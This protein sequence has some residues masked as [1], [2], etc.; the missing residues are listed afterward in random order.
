MRVIFATS[1][2]LNQLKEARRWFIDGT[3]KLVKP[4]FYQ[5]STMH[6]FVKKGDDTKQVP[7]VYVQMSRLRRKTIL[8]C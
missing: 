8:V 5:L 3:F 1:Y 7:L 6:A 4:P 2:Q